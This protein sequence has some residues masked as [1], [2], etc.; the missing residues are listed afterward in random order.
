MLRVWRYGKDQ[1][2]GILPRHL[3]SISDNVPVSSK[4]VAAKMSRRVLQVGM[5][6]N[7]MFKT[8]MDLKPS[9]DLGNILCF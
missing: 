5:Q 6:M 2:S 4:G 9:I 8:V 1:G 7:M 3:Q